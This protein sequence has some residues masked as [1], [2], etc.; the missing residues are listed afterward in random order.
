MKVGKVKQTW[1][2]HKSPNAEPRLGETTRSPEQSPPSTTEAIPKSRKLR[3]RSAFRSDRDVVGSPRGSSPMT[4]F[5][6]LLYNYLP[7]D[8]AEEG[9][10]IKT[11]T[12]RS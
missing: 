8:I 12:I 5:G 3:P 9:F 11:W 7:L 6:N 1:T 2:N 4:L 10:K